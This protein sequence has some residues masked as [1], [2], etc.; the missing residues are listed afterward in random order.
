MD[1]RILAGWARRGTPIARQIARLQLTEKPRGS[2][3][4]TGHS[5]RILDPF[6]HPCI[7]RT[8]R[9]AEPESSSDGIC[10]GCELRRS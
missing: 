6:R 9:I 5:Q 7:S 10:V 4:H 2:Q 8:R 1:P 3:Q